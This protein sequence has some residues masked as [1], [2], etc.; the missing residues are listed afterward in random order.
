[1]KIRCAQTQSAERSP[2]SLRASHYALCFAVFL[3]FF[4]CEHKLTVSR[5]EGF[6]STADQMELQADGGNSTR[7][8][9]FGGLGMLGV[10]LSL[11]RPIPAVKFDS[12]LPLCVIGFFLFALMSLTWSDSPSMTFRRFAVLA[13]FA[14]GAFGI[15]KFFTLTELLYLVVFVCSLILAIGFLCE[16][17]LGTFRPWASDYRFSGTVHPNTQGLYLTSLCLASFCLMRQGAAKYWLLPIFAMSLLF[18]L[19]TKS[20][21]SCAGLVLALS[22]IWIL[23]SPK[24]LIPIVAV[25]GVWFAATIGFVV[26]FLALD[27]TKSAS[28]AVLLGREEQAESLTGRLPIWETLAPYVQDRFLL[29]YGYDSFWIPAHVNAVSSE[30]HWGIREAHSAYVEMLLSVGLIG[31]ACWLVVVLWTLIRAVHSYYATYH[32]GHAFFFGLILFG[33]IN[34]FTESGM[35]MPLFVPFV[36]LAG[37]MHHAFFLENAPDPL[38]V[39]VP[40]KTSFAYQA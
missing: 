30:L 26:S 16:L 1:M 6:T 13:C 37:I 22:A 14:L 25:S 29:G 18:L 33:L 4:L 17:S 38:R 19:L 35:I 28:N 31:A 40:S 36:V 7:R 21:T 2:Q 24:G 32:E 5:D 34:G 23:R 15:S 39:A 11:N 8:L 3:I 27:L 12:M 10:A 20:R 9:V